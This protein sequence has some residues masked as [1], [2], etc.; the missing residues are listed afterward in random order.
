MKVLVVTGRL[1]SRTIKQMIALSNHVELH[2]IT[3]VIPTGADIF[4]TVTYYNSPKALKDALVRF[5]DMDI[6]HAISEPSWVVIACKE[7]LPSKKIVLDWHDAQVWRSDNPED[8]S[9]EERIVSNW[10]DGIIVPSQPCKKLIKPKVP[11]VVLPPYFNEQNTA[12][13]SWGYTG[14]IVYE[15]RVDIPKFRKY[16]DYCKYDE[17]CKKFMES[18]IAFSIYSPFS[19]RKEH[20]DVYENICS[21]NKGQTH[22]ELI[23][24]MGI[25][26]WGLCGNLNEYKEWDLSMPNKLFEYMAAGIPIIALNAKETG[27]F[28]E[29]HGV[30]IY[31][32]SIDEIKSRWCERDKCQRNVFLKRNQFS[33][34]KHIGT[35]I[36]LYKRVLS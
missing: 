9:T 32:K 3:K 5:N 22:N 15:G 33:M 20:K 7:V 8:G 29:K 19:D 17:L 26:D 18:D 1:C 2:L 6:I 36:D 10:V 25:Y 24:L 21:W 13:N 16:M 35:V 11:C 30:G 34:E 23:N 12:Y 28:V 14:G 27:K 4:K 31:V